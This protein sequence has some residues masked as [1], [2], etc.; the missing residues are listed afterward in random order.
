MTD[1]SCASEC[2]GVSFR[3]WM[4]M[5]RSSPAFRAGP[6]ITSVMARP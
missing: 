3:L 4:I 5:P 6:S 2:I 1:R